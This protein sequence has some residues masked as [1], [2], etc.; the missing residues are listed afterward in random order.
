[1]V[2]RHSGK[3]TLPQTNNALPVGLIRT[4][5]DREQESGTRQEMAPSMALLSQR[6]CHTL[7]KQMRIAKDEERRDLV[8]VKLFDRRVR[9]LRVLWRDSGAQ[10]PT[11]QTCVSE[12]LS[13]SPLA[14][15]MVRLMAVSSSGQIGR[16]SPWGSWRRRISEPDHH[17]PLCPWNPCICSLDYLHL[18]H[19]RLRK[20]YCLGLVSSSHFH[21]CSHRY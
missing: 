19:H 20:D 14:Y 12:R 13:L 15:V 3:P 2:A 21:F 6:A 10:A 7:M 18:T 9:W 8:E 17:Q 1:L 11:L 16:W 4:G 5:P